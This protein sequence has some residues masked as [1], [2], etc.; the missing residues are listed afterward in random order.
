MVIL[1][2]CEYEKTIK[3]STNEWEIWCCIELGLLG[4]LVLL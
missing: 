4:C 2:V 3:K 1:F